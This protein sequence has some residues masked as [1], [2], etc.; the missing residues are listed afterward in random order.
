MSDDKK[1]RK[2]ILYPVPDNAPVYACAACRGQVVF[3]VTSRGGRMPLSVATMREEDGRK[4]A[5]PHW[6]DCPEAERFRGGQRRRAERRVAEA[7]R[8]RQAEAQRRIRD[9]E[10]PG[11]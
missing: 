6:G 3:V 9:A 4:V 8:K 7:D 10:R 2:P 5:E 11:S 1:P